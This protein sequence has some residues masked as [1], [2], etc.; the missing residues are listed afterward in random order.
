[1]FR[2]WAEIDLDR[3]GEN[4]RRIRALLA[5]SVKLLVPIKANAYGHG[6]IP[7]AQEMDA[8]G[9]DAFGVASVEE[10]ARLR[11]AGITRPVL[12]LS[13]PFDDE[14]EELFRLN[15]TAT[16]CNL[17]AARSLS[18]W[19]ESR[20]RPIPVHVKID[21]GMGRLGL[22]W[23][24][25]AAAVS[26]M[27]GLPGVPMEGCFT[28]L[29][30]AEEEDT[31]WSRTQIERFHKILE[32]LREAGHG[33]PMVHALNSAGL[34]RFPEAHHNAVRPAGVLFGMNLLDPQ[35]RTI[36][37]EEVFSLRSRIQTVKTLCE[38]HPVGYGA[39]FRTSGPTRVAT[40]P[41]GYGDGLFRNGCAGA[42]VLVHG[43]RRPVLGR[44]SM[45]LLTVGLEPDDPVR[46]GDIVTL[47]G[48]DGEE[49]IS[50]EETA[51]RCGTIPY[52]ITCHVGIRVP[53]LYQ[54]NG[55][56]RDF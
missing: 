48:A 56:L 51:R 23:E 31:S 26:E 13:P 19:A 3:L 33:I 18:C 54:R 47:I 5:P 2:A 11:K 39:T 7:V 34:Q 43:R 25:A 9:V 45:D 1:M 35:L 53:R 55:E 40:V 17:E 29:G 15:L 36:A 44:I 12:V 50:V 27:A 16:V 46:V 52:E 21:T 10:G 42:P 4:V 37:V 41:V 38:G 28:H 6:V 14:F 24:E 30:C 20:G 8:L 49:R 22:P 32:A